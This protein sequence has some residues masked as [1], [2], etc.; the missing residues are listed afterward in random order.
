MDQ[1]QGRLA[2]VGLAVLGEHG[3]ALA[4]GYALQAH[5]L[6][7]RM[8]EDVGMFTDRFDT[9]A[10]SGAIEA[11]V[12]AYRQDGL[13]VEVVRRA[14]TFARVQ[15]VDPISGQASSVDLAADFRGHGPVEGPVGPVLAE[16]DAVATKVAAVF[17]R[18]YARDYLD[19]A[20]ILD[21][22]RYGREEL[23][24]LATDVDA[25]FSRTIF[26]DAL[27]AVDRFADAEFARYGPDA[28]RIA[29]VRETMRAWSR[30]L[31]DENLLGE[32]QHEPTHRKTPAPEDAK[33]PSAPSQKPVRPRQ[34]G[35]QRRSL[36]PDSS[37]GLDPERASG[38]SR[39]PEL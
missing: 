34:P 30:A 20:G 17:S 36:W 37:G 22:G 1:F 18:A 2:R 35:R 28:S 29:Q 23:I 5:K 16:V 15:A 12:E 10:F 25:G 3:F 14:D 4:G 6:V 21:S 26:S 13:E 11:L 39:G 31:Q 33:P 27:A 19:L 7:E 24:V 9:D 38:E 8:S 32:S